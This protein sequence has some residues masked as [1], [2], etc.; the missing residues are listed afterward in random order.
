MDLYFYDAIG[1]ERLN[2]VLQI[3]DTDEDVTVHINSP[4][5]SVYDGLAIYNFLTSSRNKIKVSIDGMAGSIAGVVAMAG[6]TVSI[7]QSGMF[8][9]HNASAMMGGGTKEHMEKQIEVLDKIDEIQLNIFTRKKGQSKETIQALMTK[10]TYFTSKEAKR[11][12]FVDTIIKPQK[13]A[14]EINFDKMDNLLNDIRNKFKALM[15]SLDKTGDNDEAVKK[16]KDAADAVAADKL[17]AKKKEIGDDVA[18]QLTAEM[19]LFTEYES[20]RVKFQAFADAT[21]KHIE[22]TQKVLDELDADID[23]R[24]ETAMNAL[25]AKVTS[26]TEVP[27]SKHIFQGR[28]AK[29]QTADERKKEIKD[30]ERKQEENRTLKLNPV[31]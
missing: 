18:N 10:E 3:A 21:M 22:A 9:V 8:M 17:K 25:L 26:K 2:K 15:P 11:L 6:D 20:D 24:I 30:F 16:L 12:G 5:G 29:D 13:I 23:T 28:E 14:A 19:V 31:S 27:A 1:P 4:G 7:H